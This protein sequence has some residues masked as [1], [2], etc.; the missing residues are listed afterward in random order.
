MRSEGGVEAILAFLIRPLSSAFEGE[1]LS[2][3]AQT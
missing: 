1:S 3:R 2:A